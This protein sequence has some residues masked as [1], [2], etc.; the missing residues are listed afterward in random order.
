M[1]GRRLVRIMR[2][3]SASVVIWRWAQMVPLSGQGMDVATIARVEARLDSLPS[4]CAPAGYEAKR[5]ADP[6]AHPAGS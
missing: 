1:K 2:R 6:P 5:S 4:T 3:G